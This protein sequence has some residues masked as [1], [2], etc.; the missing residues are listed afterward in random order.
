MKNRNYIIALSTVLLG[1]NGCG[2]S[3]SS[4]GSSGI[5]TPNNGTP[6]ALD[7]AYVAFAPN[8]SKRMDILYKTD[9]TAANTALVSSDMLPTNPGNYEN[10]LIS[11]FLI[12]NG[13][14]YMDRQ[15]RKGN[16]LLSCVESQQ[17][18][19]VLNSSVTSYLPIEA[20]TIVDSISSA[21]V[22]RYST[23]NAIYM[24][25]VDQNPPPVVSSVGIDSYVISKIDTGGTLTPIQNNT[26]YLPNYLTTHL[27][28]GTDIY[29]G[30]LDYTTA[31]LNGSH[32]PYYGMLKLD[33]T[34]DSLSRVPVFD[35]YF[36]HN[37]TE[38]N[39]KIYIGASIGLSVGLYMFD[40]ATTSVLPA[41]I[42]SY[43]ELPSNGFVFNGELYYLA[44]TSQGLRDIYRYDGTTAPVT[45]TTGV[46][47]VK[48]KFI[49]YNGGLYYISSGSLYESNGSPISTLADSQVYEANGKLYFAHSSAAEG[50]ELWQYDGTT[51]SL[52][53]DINP[54]TGNSMPRHITELNGDIIFQASPDGA[55]NKL[56]NYDGTNLTP[57]N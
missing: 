40:P 19:T 23:V 25:H 38:F 53:R 41:L 1:F 27:Q 8:V 24:S 36:V 31:S 50:V 44:A 12:Q 7:T 15:Q 30:A 28:V 55:N 18:K 45:I 20:S 48:F 57:L 49:E 21:A 10:E 47:P 35:G 4:S 16:C 54:G 39:S 2:S 56:Y 13:I 29:Y 34:F 9:G 52:V 43:A 11:N 3:P 22:T 17:M 14:L 26:A 33:T 51:A 32:L 42:Q 5:T 46:S 6:S 37:M